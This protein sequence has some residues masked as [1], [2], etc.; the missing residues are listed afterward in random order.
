MYCFISG[1]N[2]FILLGHLDIFNLDRVIMWKYL[3]LVAL[4]GLTGQVAAQCSPSPCGVNTNCEVR[5]L[6][7]N[8]SLTNVHNLGRGA[9]LNG[10]FKRTPS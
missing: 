1:Y 3:G 6:F 9:E 8:Y 10:N 5:L 7:S 2:I 4:I